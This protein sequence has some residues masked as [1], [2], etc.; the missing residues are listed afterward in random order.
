[1]R[2]K[3]VKLIHPVAYSGPVE[4]MLD[5][6]LGVVEVDG[7][8]IVAKAHGRKAVLVPMS[9]VAFFEEFAEG[10][11]EAADKAYAAKTA[12]KQKTQ[13]APVK[14]APVVVDDR[15]IVTKDEFGRIVERRA[16]EV[17][18]EAA[19]DLDELVAESDS[20]TADE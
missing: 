1:M 2:L 19:P 16:S 4:T 18:A 3:R 20:A 12:P 6:R 9:N 8:Y 10:E 13:P 5:G 11:A 15:I 14:V 7:E 17:A